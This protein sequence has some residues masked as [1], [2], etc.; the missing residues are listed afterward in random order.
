MIDSNWILTI[1]AAQRAMSVQPR[2]V[3]KKLFFVITLLLILNLVGVYLVQILHLNTHTVLKLVH[4][5]DFNEEDNI[6]TFFSVQLLLLASGLLLI[7]AKL[8]LSHKMAR[9][10]SFLSAVFLF[11]ALDESISIHEQFSNLINNVYHTD[12]KM[13][14]YLHFS[15]V[16][17]Y[18]LG[19]TVLTVIYA[20]FIWQ[21]PPFIRTFFVLSGCVFVTGAMG[22]EIIEAHYSVLHG[23]HDLYYALLYTLEET[24]E[25]SGV[26]LFIYAL[27][28]YIAQKHGEIK[29]SITNSK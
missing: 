8:E 17:P 19:L 5:F 16:L 7:I 20:P 18:A 26:V 21:L 25:M 11:L 14:G 28:T 15:W 23:T 13:S 10:W 6:P 3:A 27:I 2:D 9:R 29:L 12:T 24:M 4:F 1:P 22:L